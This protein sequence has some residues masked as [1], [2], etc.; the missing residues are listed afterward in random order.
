MAGYQAS[1]AVSH[2]PTGMPDVLKLT[3]TGHAGL[4][5]LQASGNDYP[6]TK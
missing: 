5:D 6:V 2:C 3:P 4:K 1:V